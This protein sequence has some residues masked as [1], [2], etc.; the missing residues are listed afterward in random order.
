MKA[1]TKNP[2]ITG[3]IVSI[4]HDPDR[5]G[6]SLGIEHDVPPPITGPRRPFARRQVVRG[7]TSYVNVTR[8]LLPALPPQRDTPADRKLSRWVG[9]RVTVTLDAEDPTRAASIEWAP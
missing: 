9:T 2:T 5:A 6:V 7:A 1:K 3:T 8:D 4:A